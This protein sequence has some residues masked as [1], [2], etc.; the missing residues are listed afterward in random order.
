MRPSA[1]PGASARI[2]TAG[3]Q[4]PRWRR[5][6]RE[7]YY[8][9]ADGAVMAVDVDLAR[10]PRLG[11]PRVVLAAAPFAR[12]DR[13][14]EVTADGQTFVSFGRG[15]APVFTLLLDWAARLGSP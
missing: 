3:G 9:R 11:S 12:T 6:A 13:G 5:D 15:A 1:G 4:F 7:L 8:Q 2:S 14:I 10:G